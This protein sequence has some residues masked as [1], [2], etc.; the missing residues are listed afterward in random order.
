[1]HVLFLDILGKHIENWSVFALK[2]TFEIILGP[3][4]H[5][6]NE[7]KIKALSFRLLTSMRYACTL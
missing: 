7:L 6:I 5:I 1:M 2:T 3:Q 4:K